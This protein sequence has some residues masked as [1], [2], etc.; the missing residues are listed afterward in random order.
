MDWHWQNFNFGHFI[1]IHK[2]K[3]VPVGLFSLKYLNP[4][5]DV[6]TAVPDLGYFLDKSFWGQGLATEGAKGLA[7]YGFNKLLLNEVGAL[8][9]PENSASSH[10]LK[11]VGFQPTSEVEVIYH[12]RNFGTATKWQLLKKDFKPLSFEPTEAFKK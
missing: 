8:N 3:H 6:N 7:A 12:G 9:Y 5:A 4:Q 10:V 1:A 2:R 11:K